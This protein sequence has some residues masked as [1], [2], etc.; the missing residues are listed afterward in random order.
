MNLRMEPE[1]IRALSCWLKEPSVWAMGNKGPAGV[2]RKKTHNID[3]YLPFG[4]FIFLKRGVC[5]CYG[6]GN[7]TGLFNFFFSASI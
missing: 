1:K 7:G 5:S 3:P 4:T 2:E 6:P